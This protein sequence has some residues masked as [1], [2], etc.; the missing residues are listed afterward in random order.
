MFRLKHEKFPDLEISIK[1]LTITFTYFQI[2]I[3]KYAVMKAINF[4]ARKQL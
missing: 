3:V 2:R 1:Y 4:C